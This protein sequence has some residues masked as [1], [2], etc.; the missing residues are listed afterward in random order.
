MKHKSQH[1][2]GCTQPVRS[3]VNTDG[4]AEFFR[5][6][7]AEHPDPHAICMVCIGT[8][9][10]T[11]DAYGPLV[12]TYLT[13]LG[14]PCVIGTLQEPYDAVRLQAGDYALPAGRLVLAIDACLGKPDSIG[15]YVVGAGPLRPAEAV[16][17]P[18]VEIG[19]YS[20]A[21]VVN[22]MGIKPYWIL[23]GT[24]LHLVMEMAKQTAAAI[25]Q[26]WT[27]SALLPGS[28]L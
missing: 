6:V 7:A 23:Q 17:R 25:R 18:F 3:V 27:S 22:R 5:S 28:G 20:V 8:D 15:S 11:G 13:E 4:L 21:G 24:S 2:E 26:A 10:S 12:G 1:P 9:R 16:G 14:W 19:D